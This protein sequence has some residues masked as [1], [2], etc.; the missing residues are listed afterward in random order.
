M[1]EESV[2]YLLLKWKDSQ[3]F[4]KVRVESSSGDRSFFLVSMGLEA[5]FL[6]SMGGDRLLSL[7]TGLPG[8][9]TWNAHVWESS[10]WLMEVPSTHHSK[11][12]F[13]ACHFSSSVDFWYTSLYHPPGW[14]FR[15]LVC[16]LSFFLVF[17]CNRFY[18][19]LV[20]WTSAF[21]VDGKPILILLM[22]LV[23]FI[24]RDMK[25]TSRGWFWIKPN[26][27]KSVYVRAISLSCEN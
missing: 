11:H 23:S 1:H 21:F 19:W 16:F 10:L 22:K 24:H 7:R 17:V 14:K 26:L 13:L 3:G 9:T 4:F 12:L 20:M 2:F 5:F 15:P 8:M 27:P 25:N 18:G 6:I